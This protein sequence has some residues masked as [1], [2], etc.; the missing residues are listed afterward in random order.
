MEGVMKMMLLN[1][2]KSNPL[3]LLLVGLLVLGS[4]PLLM[5]ATAQDQKQVTT[6]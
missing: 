3:V 1:K 5:Q 6:K 2:L 4:M